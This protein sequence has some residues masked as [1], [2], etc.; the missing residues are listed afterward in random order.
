MW[1]QAPGPLATSARGPKWLVPA[2]VVV[3]VRVEVWLRSVPLV[4]VALPGS[5][6]EEPLRGELVPGIPPPS[7]RPGRA[8]W[9]AGLVELLEVLSPIYG[10]L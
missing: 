4:E 2:K 9:W 1:Q 3:W 10:P 6:W 8:T 5:V 7:G